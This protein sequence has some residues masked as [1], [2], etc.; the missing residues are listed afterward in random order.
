ME[1]ESV[2]FPAPKP[3]RDNWLCLNPLPGC[4]PALLTSGSGRRVR[5]PQ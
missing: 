5:R 1:Q 3:F 2:D 4:I